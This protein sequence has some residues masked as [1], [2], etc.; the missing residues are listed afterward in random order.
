MKTLAVLAATLA[1][2]AIT[3]CGSTPVTTA[4]AGPSYATTLP[5]LPAP[6][7]ASTPAAASSQPSAV[8]ATPSTEPSAS[9][10]APATPT[11]AAG[12]EVNLVFTGTSEFS[13]IGTAGRCVLIKAADGSVQSFGF[14]VSESDYPGLGQS[15]SLAELSPGYVDIKWVV[16]ASSGYARPGPAQGGSD[17]DLI[18]SADKHTV[19]IDSDLSPFAAAGTTPPGPEHV[20][21]T[22]TCP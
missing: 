7:N 19:T 6:S 8:A 17:S 13:A 4:V 14:E 1:V 15:F 16:D 18:L 21:G 22:I 9:S 10:V 20:A 3:G 2:V 12:S 11:T 5:P